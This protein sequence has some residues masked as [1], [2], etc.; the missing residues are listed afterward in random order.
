MKQFSVF[1][2]TPVAVIAPAAYAS[3]YLSVEQAQQ[4]IFPKASF[5]LEDLALKPRIWRVPGAGWFIVD[6]VVGKSELITYAVGLDANGAVRG[7]EILEYR[8]SHGGEVRNPGWRRQFVGKSAADPVRL[9]DDIRNISGATLSCR[10]V[11]EGVKRLLVLYET[12]L[13][14][15]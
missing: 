14:G 8:E 4:A 2:F 1:L 9:D 11:T 7:I 15:R 12:A 10:H 3:V 5:V 13:K 6:Q